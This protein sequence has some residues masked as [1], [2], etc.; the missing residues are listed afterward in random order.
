MITLT[1]D[2]P[3]F[4]KSITGKTYNTESKPNNKTKNL[5]THF[6]TLAK[7]EPF[8]KSKIN[9]IQPTTETRTTENIK[10]FIISIK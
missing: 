3:K 5:K 2:S 7:L 9:I 1:P 8:H 6:T 4:S 10:H